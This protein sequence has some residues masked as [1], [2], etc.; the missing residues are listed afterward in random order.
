MCIPNSSLLLPFGSQP[1]ER[2][3]FSKLHFSI[4]TT[5]GG[6]LWLLPFG[7]QGTEAQYCL[8]V[9]PRFLND[10]DEITEN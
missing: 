6:I 10:N 1:T 7:S 3:Y 9:D 5:P 2:Q 8:S 4:A